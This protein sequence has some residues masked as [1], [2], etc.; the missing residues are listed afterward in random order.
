VIR[1]TFKGEIIDI[2]KQ[3][4]NKR[5]TSKLMPQIRKPLLEQGNIE[6][7]MKKRNSYYNYICLNSVFMICLT[8][9]EVLMR[10]M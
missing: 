1:R 10:N 3:D 9:D 5:K 8:E 4:Y 7:N 6:D 2:V